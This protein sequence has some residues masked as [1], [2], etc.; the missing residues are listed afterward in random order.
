MSSKDKLIA[1]LKSVPNNFTFD[2]MKSVLESLGF[3]LINQGKISGSRVG[4]KKGEI[5]IKLHKPHPQKEMAQ[6][7]LKQILRLL[8]EKEMI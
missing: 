4:F 6:Y 3:A 7:Q 2:E 1:R 5:L 8:E